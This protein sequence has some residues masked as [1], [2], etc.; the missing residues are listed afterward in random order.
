M[1]KT[2]I[3]M[4]KEIYDDEEI[5]NIEFARNLVLRALANNEITRNS[6]KRLIEAVWEMQGFKIIIPDF[7]CS[8]ET[9]RRVRQQIQHEGKYLPTIPEIARKRKIKE[10]IW[11]TYF[12]DNPKI[13][14][15]FI[16]VYYEVA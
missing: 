16:K 8:P 15:R 2:G 9:I 7:V 1:Q 3:S 12:N 4:R 6:D 11:R 10:Q 14:D 13:L 5:E